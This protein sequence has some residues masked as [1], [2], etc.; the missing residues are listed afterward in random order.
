VSIRTRYEKLAAHVVST[1]Q[2]AESAGVVPSAAT[3]WTVRWDDFPAPLARFGNVDLYPRDEVE[4][5]LRRHGR[6]I[7]WKDTS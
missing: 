3:N 2:I 1:A 7:T 4:D 6:I 5:C